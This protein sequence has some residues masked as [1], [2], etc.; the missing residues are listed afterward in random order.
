MICLQ[1]LGLCRTVKMVRSHTAPRGAQLKQLTRLDYWI[2][3]GNWQSPGAARGRAPCASVLEPHHKSSRSRYLRELPTGIRT[4]K[5]RPAVATAALGHT[6]Y[7][8]VAQEQGR[9]HL[10]SRGSKHGM[11]PTTTEGG[12]TRLTR[13]HWPLG[14]PSEP[15]ETARALRARLR[16]PHGPTRPAR[17]RPGLQASGHGHAR[18]R[19]AEGVSPVLLGAIGRSM[20]LQTREAPQESA[21]SANIYRIGRARPP[22]VP[23][24]KKQ[25]HMRTRG[26]SVADT[27]HR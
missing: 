26:V 20:A 11:S 14:S 6:L 18:G 22:D 12:K 15:H 16:P 3:K 27:R 23:A 25:Q 9:V 7:P 19:L 4:A 1:R 13:T 24:G 17:C 8:P 21:G 5:E 10:T 2:L